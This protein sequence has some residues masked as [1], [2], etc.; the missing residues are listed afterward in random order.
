M[1]TVGSKVSQKELEAIQEYANQCG[2]TVSNLIRKCVI[3]MAIMAGNNTNDISDY[4]FGVSIPDDI[5]GEQQDKMM[6][7]KV[8]G[9]RKIL[10]W[11]ETKLV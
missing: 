2:E 6:E 9:I 11:K 5:P 3:Q 8:N 7:E 10:G 4:D 1:P